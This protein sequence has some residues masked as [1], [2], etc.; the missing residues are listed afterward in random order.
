VFADLIATPGVEEFHRDGAGVGVMAIHG[1]IEEGTD[2]I[3]HVVTEA[4]GAALYTV[5]Q[6]QTLRWHVPSIRFDPADSKRL[7]RFLDSV[8][9]VISL[10]GYGE[11]GLEG[12]ALL[13]GK[14]R[15]LAWAIHG[16]LAARGIAAVADLEGIPARLR[17]IHRLNPVNRPP[18]AGTQI[19]LPM[20]LRQGRPM[21]A[22][23]EALVVSVENA[24][25]RLSGKTTTG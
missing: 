10:H 6:P 23:I 4:T 18:L 19:E 5:V 12:T 24:I 8:E 25:A 13:G 11:P 17:G 14:N 7:R 20:E 16:E 2:S 3:A 21:H 9:T 22:V 1:G 15:T